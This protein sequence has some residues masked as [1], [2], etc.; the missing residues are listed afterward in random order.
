[1]LLK[2]EGIEPVT[3]REKDGL[4]VISSNAFSAGQAASVL[5]ETELLLKTA[6]IIA[7]MS[8]EGLSGNVSSLREG[9][10]NKRRYNR[11]TETAADMRKYLKGSYLYDRVPA[12]R[13]RIR[14]P[15]DA[16]RRFTELSERLWITPPPI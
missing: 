8:L 10:H 2:Q 9:V 16:F 15:T 14:C 1:M 13:S 3:L 6:D 11:Q 7:C 12:V 4:A 5:F